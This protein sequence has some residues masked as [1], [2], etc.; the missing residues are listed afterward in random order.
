HV[1]RIAFYLRR[2]AIPRRVGLTDQGRA[3]F[4]QA[5]CAVCHAP[6][7]RTRAD[8][9][10]PQLANIDAPVYTDMLLHDLGAALADGMTDQSALS[11]EW[12]TAP[13]IGLRFM[14]TFLHDGRAASV[15]DA[16]VAHDGEAKVAVDLFLGMSAG[17]QAALVTFVEAL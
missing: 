4:A 12:R 10:I 16:I 2:I 13:L 5:K 8:Y 7:L 11:P 17:D 6:S 3:L 15:R 14:K 1:D 9:P